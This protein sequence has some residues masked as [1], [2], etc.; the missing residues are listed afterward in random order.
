MNQIEQRLY[1][2]FYNPR[3]GLTFSAKSLYQT[4]PKAEKSRT[5]IA[6][7]D[8]FIKKQEVYQLLR[9]AP[10]DTRA[11]EKRKKYRPDMAGSIINIDLLDVSKLSMR[12][13]GIKYL[14]TA[15]DLYDSYAYIIPMKNKSESTSLQAI[16]TLL[17]Q[18]KKHIN[19][20]PYE[21][22]SDQGTEFTN[23]SVQEFLKQT[24]IEHTLSFTNDKR[25]NS[26][27]ERFNRT[28]RNYIAR[29]TASFD[30][31]YINNLNNFLKNY[32][33]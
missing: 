9:P 19:Y 4:L 25:A 31:R 1:E 17:K 10:K 3:T 27:V 32:N 16:K 33:D 11:K 29:Y 26:F 7:V 20:Y 12:N 14:L 21:L 15:I 5:T 6:D 23:K 22:K 13:K 8:R 2:R 28:V 18:I 30:N 24:K